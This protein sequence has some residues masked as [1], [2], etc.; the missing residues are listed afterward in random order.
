MVTLLY[1]LYGRVL[2]KTQVQAEE[3]EKKCI[4]LEAAAVLKEKYVHLVSSL[5]GDLGEPLALL[6]DNLELPDDHFEEDP[7]IVKNAE[8]KLNSVLNVHSDIVANTDNVEVHSLAKMWAHLHAI[9]DRMHQ[10]RDDLRAVVADMQNS[11]VS[12]LKKEMALDAR[13]HALDK[14]YHADEELEHELDAF[15]A[16]NSENGNKLYVG[17]D[18]IHDSDLNAS[19]S[20]HHKGVIERGAALVKGAT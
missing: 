4:A 16:L 18:S 6:R 11:T 12:R 20:P 2:S 17:D 7:D 14:D 13:L 8:T 19:Y 15:K 10:Y 1:K 3:A 5:L 9:N